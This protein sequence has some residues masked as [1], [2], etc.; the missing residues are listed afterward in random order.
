LALGQDE[1]LG[2]TEN[3]DPDRSKAMFV[4]LW[5][6]A[7]IKTYPVCRH[8][9]EV[10]AQRHKGTKEAIKQNQCNYL[11]TADWGVNLGTFLPVLRPIRALDM[12][13]QRL[14]CKP[15]RLELVIDE[16]LHLVGIMLGRR[17]R[18]CGTVRLD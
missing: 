11:N 12:T 14:P 10:L 18:G 17:T 1:R 9:V 5:L 16:Q 15:Y 8:A 2:E 7:S 4:P 6:C 3:G 13:L